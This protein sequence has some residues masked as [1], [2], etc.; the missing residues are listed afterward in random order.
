MKILRSH[1][2]PGDALPARF[3][4]YAVGLFPELPSRNG[5]KK[6]IKRGE[7]L[8]NGEAAET[9]RWIVPGCR[10]D[11]VEDEKGPAAPYRLRIKVYYE[12]DMLAV[13]GKP[14]GITVTGNRFKTMENALPINLAPSSSYDALPR[15]RPV[16][17]L[18]AQTGGLL[19]VAKTRSSLMELGRL[20]E[21]RAVEKRYLA[22][23][24]G[25]LEGRGVCT[26]PVGGR[27][28]LT[29]YAGMRHVP[30][31]KNGWLT[32]AELLPR[33]GRTHQLRVHLAG[34]GHPV[35]GD[36]LYGK[37]GNILRG[38]GLF[39]YAAALSFIHPVTGAPVR[40]ESPPPAKF[41]ALLLREERRWLK[42]NAG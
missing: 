33:T 32:L 17:R 15:P 25:K 19:L 13:I 24:A 12:D 18:D 8:V 39:L 16:H 14:P 29:E 1:I 6:A 31:L 26:A 28:A 36:P 2:V 22:V 7:L 5:A 42:Y 30:S 23:V 41:A 37:E 11:M 9:G 20:M 21:D 3:S 40:V 10:I 27:E 38:K 4:D 34:M 35:M